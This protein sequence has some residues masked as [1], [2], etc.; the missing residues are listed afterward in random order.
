MTTFGIDS[1]DRGDFTC[2]QFQPPTS[3]EQLVFDVLFGVV[4]PILCFVF[5]PG[6]LRTS[7]FDFGFGVPV[8]F[9]PQFAAFIYIASG[10]EI[11][12]LTAWLAWGRR[13]ETATQLAG[14]I[15]MAG[16]LFSGFIGLILFPFSLM[17]LAIGIGVFGFVPF[18]TALV[19]LRN[20]RSAFQ[21]AAKH[22]D[23]PRST[24]VGARGL[25]LRRSPLLATM[26][27]GLLVLGPPAALSVAA[28]MFMSQAMEAVLSADEQQ[29]DLAIDEIRYL[30]FF[31]Q[32]QVNKLVFEYSA[33]NEPSRKEELKRRYLKLTGNDIEQRLRFIN[34]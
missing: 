23:G 33:T 8:A 1:N 16:A 32:P 9:F 11:L 14:G 22:S 10:I 4:A 34:D 18:L 19:Y 26:A 12:L 5:D 6:I 13:M 27:G 31:A 2:R 29:A 7:G 24:P 21:V 30:Q 28:C 20:A 25:T 17:G 15:L 3:R